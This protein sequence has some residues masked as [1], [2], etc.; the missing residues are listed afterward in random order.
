MAAGKELFLFDSGGVQAW[1]KTFG[2]VSDAAISG[3]GA[4]IVAAVSDSSSSYV[5]LVMDR[6]G[7]TLSQSTLGPSEP[8][9]SVSSDASYVAVGS[10]MD[11][12]L[13]T[14]QCKQL[15]SRRMSSSVGSVAVSSGGLVAVEAY[16]ISLFDGGGKLLWGGDSETW[17]SSGVSISGDGKYVAAAISSNVT[18]LDAVGKKVWSRRVGERLSLEDVAM[19]LDGASVAAVARS[20][21]SPGQGMVYILDN[22]PGTEVVKKPSVLPSKLGCYS[23]HGYLLIGG[24]SR[25]TGPLPL[26]RPPPR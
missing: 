13:M 2:D 11:V 24:A 22:P 1:K 25:S 9:L 21:Y 4:Y 12:I 20:L 8:C 19:S 7:N 15:W 14:R 3:D 6:G 23:D 10:S 16:S 5:V 18:L 26:R 17:G